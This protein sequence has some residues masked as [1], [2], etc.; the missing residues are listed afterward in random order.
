MI[1]VISW[2]DWLPSVADIVTNVGILAAF[3][4]LIAGVLG[5]ILP[6]P[7]HVVMLGGFAL[8][9]ACSDKD[10]S[11]W[12]I[13]T[14]LVLLALLGMVMDNV[15]TMLGAKKAGSSKTAIVC[16]MV[17]LVVGTITCFPIGVVIGPFLGAFVGE[18][19]FLRRKFEDAAKS[20]VG[21]TI[22]SLLGIAVKFVFAVLMLGVFFLCF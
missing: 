11:S 2:G 5:C 17:G 9:A 21:A 18:M 1:A 13:W 6:Y 10:Y 4:L 7:G 15:F 20:G 8:W 3:L 16:S 12:W 19:L 22:G 14:L